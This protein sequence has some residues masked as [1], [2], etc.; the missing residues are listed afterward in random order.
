M[1]HWLEHA[2]ETRDAGVTEIYSTPFVIAFRD[3]PRFAA[4]AKKVGLPPLAADAT[5]PTEPAPAPAAKPAKP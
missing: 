3:D 2:L 4:L 1:F 5:K